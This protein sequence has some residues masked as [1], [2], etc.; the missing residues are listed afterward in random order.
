[1]KW[2][3][4]RLVNASGCQNSFNPRIKLWHSPAEPRLDSPCLQHIPAS[5]FASTGASQQALLSPPLH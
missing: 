4:N 1:M 2:V 3:S 5:C